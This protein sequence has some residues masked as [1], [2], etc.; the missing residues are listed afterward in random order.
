VRA[1]LAATKA[2]DL[3]AQAGVDYAHSLGTVDQ[4][5]TITMGLGAQVRLWR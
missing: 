3:L 2:V 5:C 1:A 4:A